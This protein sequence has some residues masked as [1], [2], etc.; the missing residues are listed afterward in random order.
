MFKGR[1]LHPI[2]IYIEMRVLF[3]ELVIQITSFCVDILLAYM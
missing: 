1:Q 2:F 3:R